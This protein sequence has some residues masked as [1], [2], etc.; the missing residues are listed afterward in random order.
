MKSQRLRLSV[1]RRVFHLLDECRDLGQDPVRWL[2]KAA[3]GMCKIV[4]A[5]IVLAALSQPGPFQ[6]FE[7]AI[8]TFDTGWESPI[9]RGHCLKYIS[10]SEYHQSPDF[11]AFRAMARERVVVSRQQLVEDRDWYRTTHYQENWRPGGADH[12]LVGVHASPDRPG[13]TLFNFSRAEGREPFGPG[14]AK[15]VELFQD[16]LGRLLGHGLCVD[17]DPVA[18]LSPQHRAVLDSLLAGDSEKQVALRMGLSPHTVHDYVKSLYRKLG[19]CS[20]GELHARI[21]NRANP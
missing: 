8:A 10:G 11:L 18:T 2:A 19:V 1:V 7:T 21:R 3:D 14:E 15:V 5:D 12:Y 9:H 20:R 16:E 6:G 13:T 17:H 4:E